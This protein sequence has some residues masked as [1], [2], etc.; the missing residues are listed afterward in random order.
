[1]QIIM[2]ETTEADTVDTGEKTLLLT[3][4]SVFGKGR[5]HLDSVELNTFPKILHIEEICGRL[6]L[7]RIRI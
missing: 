6:V 2:S 7:T 4:N 3:L 5:L 1:M